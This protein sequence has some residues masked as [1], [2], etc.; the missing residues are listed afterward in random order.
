MNHNAVDP[1]AAVTAD[2]IQSIA[3]G[4]DPY[5]TVNEFLDH[6]DYDFETQVFGRIGHRYGGSMTDKVL[7]FSSDNFGDDGPNLLS[8]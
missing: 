2:Y 6:K 8:D 4:T 3:E 1:V 7:L 5:K